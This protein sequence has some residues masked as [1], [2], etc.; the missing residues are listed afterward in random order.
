MTTK[1]ICIGTGLASL[2]FLGSMVKLGVMVGSHGL[3][4]SCMTMI[5]P[6]MGAFFGVL[7]A[8]GILAVLFVVRSFVAT[9]GLTVGLPTLCA[10]VSWHVSGASKERT[11]RIADVLLH[12][13]LPVL[14]MIVF[15]A[16]TTGIACCYALYWL[17]PVAGY[18][19]RMRGVDSLFVQA[20]SSTFIAH[21]VGSIIW[22]FVVPMSPVQWVALIPLV[23]VER[24]ISAVGMT[25]VYAGI[26]KLEVIVRRSGV[27]VTKI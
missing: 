17:I 1:N 8:F 19:A 7:P 23:A 20:L 2:F 9:T 21:A 13:C 5:A 26:K 25:A 4:F 3:H 12:V 22:L 18:L 6:L 24:F 10:T 14:S 11:T 27:I 16:A 15:C